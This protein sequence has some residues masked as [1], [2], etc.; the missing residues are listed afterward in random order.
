[1]ASLHMGSLPSLRRQQ[2]LSE[3]AGLK[4][5]C[6][7]GIFV[8]LTPGNPSIWS[9]VLFVRDGPYTPAILRF[10]ITF[11]DSY[12]RLPPLVTFSTDMFHPLITPL[13]TY[14][15][16]TD[17]QDNGT[18]S[19]TDEERLPP[20]GF[21]LRHGFPEW[22]GR[23]RRSA[24]GS[25]QVSGQ[26]PGA[27][28]SHAN[29]ND[30][31]SPASKTSPRV[32]VPL[33]MQTSRNTVSAY[34]ILRYIRSAFDDEL[35]LDSVPLAAAGNPG[36]WHAWRT[37]RRAVGKLQEEVGPTDGNQEQD[38][39][40]VQSSGSVPDTSKS[41]PSASSARQ[42]AEWNW[43]GVW[44]DRV[45]K[46][47][48]TSLS[49]S[50]LYGATGSPDDLI[51]FLAMEENDVDS[52]KE[53][54]RRTLGSIS[55]SYSVTVCQYTR[56]GRKDREAGGA[57]SYEEVGKISPV[58]GQTVVKATAAPKQQRCIEERTSPLRKLG[59]IR[60]FNSC[61]RLLRQHGIP[62]NRRWGCGGSRGSISSYTDDSSKSV[63]EFQ[64]GV[65][66]LTVMKRRRT[67]D[68]QEPSSEN[69]EP[70]LSETDEEPS[71]DE[72]PIQD[73]E[74][75][76]K[77]HVSKVL[78]VYGLQ[79]MDRVPK[80]AEDG[81]PLEP[82]DFSSG[83]PLAVRKTRQADTV[84]K[85]HNEKQRINPRASCTLP[86]SRGLHKAKRRPPLSNL[87]GISTVNAAESHLTTRPSPSSPYKSQPTTHHQ[88]G[89]ACVLAPHI[90]VTTETTALEAGQHRMWAA[91]KVSGRLSQVSSETIRADTEQP[92]LETVS[93]VDTQQGSECPAGLY[94]EP[95]PQDLDG[96]FEFGCLYDLNIEILPTPGTSVLQVLR[97]QSFP[98]SVPHG[99]RATICAGSSVLILAKLQVSVKSASQVKGNSAHVRQKSD[100][101]IEDLEVELGDSQVGYMQ[102]VV[103]YSHSAFPHL[104]N[105]E[106]VDGVS[107]L[108]SKLETT[109]TAT[110]KLH[111]TPKSRSKPDLCHDA[112]SRKVTGTAARAAPLVPIRHASL[113]RVREGAVQPPSVV[114]GS[115][116][117]MR[118]V[119]S[120]AAPSFSTI[121]G[122][123]SSPDGMQAGV[124]RQS[125]ADTSPAGDQ[126]GA[127]SLWKR[128]SLG[129][130]TLRGLFPSLTDLTMTLR[131][132]DRKSTPERASR[133][134]NKKDTGRWGW[135]GW[136]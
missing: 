2:L 7:E 105:T 41:T 23:G 78:G 59:R 67:Q 9:G 58:N 95:Q 25:R 83:P 98:T 57:E 54:L 42:P 100:D 81:L 55:S 26:K 97:E 63:S 5:A 124:G 134:K 125:P 28:S 119:T 101:L 68:V 117:E 88:R 80:S 6:P 12:P 93:F 113:P 39:V 18:V 106:S 71:Q 102:I 79:D 108:Q 111:N 114:Q 133:G 130:E 85:Y 17:I 21:S 40:K 31:S 96:F 61:S 48:T 38:G 64:Q 43:N 123:E 11:P 24:A 99:H 75:N 116:K 82:S 135:G 47:V 131:E 16:T 121:E 45:K 115:W 107:T 52:V 87:L 20:G 27:T 104:A 50:V 109:A 84:A 22:F 136:F 92:G 91:I 62:V 1:M 128:R 53:N 120:G 29:Q 65:G 14:M 37:H 19:A 74:P 51:R 70:T 56:P 76:Q 89:L 122:P 86:L 34:D 46:G 72:E 118:R 8:S 69:E 129:T 3:F 90:A 10:Q 32:E 30:A 73:E 94:K 4:Q 60:I 126:G 132:Q 49:E 77:Q 35:V 110:M 13:T 15:Y 112:R 33:Y 103:T 44:E 66:S 127:T 36:A